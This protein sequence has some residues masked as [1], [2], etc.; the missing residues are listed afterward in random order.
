MKYILPFLFL[1]SSVNLFATLGDGDSAAD[2]T[3]TDIDG[4]VHNL[5]D[6]LDEGYSVIVDMSATWCGPCWSFHQ[7]GVLDDIWSDYGPSGEDMVITL[8]IEVDAATNQN[9]FF[10]SNGCNNST[11]GDWSSGVDFPLANPPSSEASDIA[12]DYSVTVLPTMYVISP[13]Q[14]V[15]AFT[16]SNTTYED[17]T[18]W[19]AYTF[20]LYNSTWEEGGTGC[21]DGFIDLH[22]FQGEGELEFEW[23]NGE[24]TEDL[25]GLPGGEYFVTITDDNLSGNGDF[26]VVIGPIEI[27][28]DED[29]E[30]MYID[31]YEIEEVF[32]FD[33]E[34]GYIEIFVEGGS[35]DFSYEWSNGGDESFIE[36]LGPGEYEVT[37]IDEDT[38]CELVDIFEVFGPEELEIDYDLTAAPCPQEFGLV[39]FYLEGATPPFTYIIEDED[40]DDDDI[41]LLP[42]YYEV[43]IIDNNDCE[44]YIEF[45]IE[46][47]DELVAIVSS[48]E[49]ELSCMN[50]SIS[51]YSDGSSEGNDIDYIW[52]DEEGLILSYAPS[53]EVTEAG[54]YILEVQREDSDCFET[55]MIEIF[56]D[57]QTPAITV[58]TANQIDCNSSTST[59]SAAGSSVGPQY[60]YNWTT[61]NGNI[62]GPTDS[63]VIVATMT[64]DYTLEIY[65]DENGCIS[66][67]TVTVTEVTLPIL[68]ISGSP[69]FCE[70]ESTDLCLS[71]LP[72][73]VAEWNL[74]G[75]N[76][77]YE[78]CINITEAQ[79]L[80]ATVTDT[81][82]GCSVSQSVTTVTMALPQVSL[83]GDLD[84]CPGS[85]TTIC[86]SNIVDMTYSW[87]ING[88]SLGSQSCIDLSMVADVTLSVTDQNTGCA[89]QETY[90]IIE[91][92]LPAISISKPE[93]LTCD[94]PEVMLD[95][96][97]DLPGYTVNWYDNNGINIANTE[98]VN[99]VNA[100]TYTAYVS[101]S[102]GCQTQSSVT[103][104][105]N[106][107]VPQFTIL[108]PAEL[109]C[110]NTEVTIDLMLNDPS[111]TVNW[112]NDSGDI[113]GNNEDLSVSD[114]GTYTAYI[115]S[116]NG[117]ETQSSVVVTANT[118]LPQFSITQPQE[119]N[120]NNA[121]VTIDLVLA[122]ATNSVSWT[123]ESG[124]I[125]SDTED[126]VVSQSGSYMATVLGNNGCTSSQIISVSADSS[127]LP[128]AAFEF[129]QNNLS[130][131]FTDQTLGN[132]YA[133]VWDFGDGN[134][135]IELDPNYLYSTAGYYLVCIETTN[136][137]GTSQTCQE[138]V[139]F[140]Q[141]E[142]SS[143]TT[144]VS[145]N[146]AADGQIMVG[147]I[148]GLG[149]YQ[150]NW[151]DNIGTDD[152]AQGLPAGTY[153]LIVQDEVGNEL[154]LSIDIIEPSAIALNPT[155]E[156]SPAGQDSG[157]I[158]LDIS[159]GTGMY[160]VLWEDGATATTRTDL[161]RGEYTVSV[162]DENLCSYSETFVIQGT[163]NSHE[164]D[165]LSSY[166]VSPN[167][168]T[169]ELYVTA[170][171]ESQLQ[172]QLSL[173]SITGERLL[174]TSDQLRTLD[175]KLDL[176]DIPNGIYLVE[177]RTKDKI[178]IK[179]V[180]ITK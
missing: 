98:D 7:D 57:T 27:E 63:L 114:S 165:G 15:K 69:E 40:Y 151:T 175:K 95:L 153:Q 103:V 90:T 92:A 24:T 137:C 60:E 56:S 136:D 14:Q 113:I 36:E 13:N 45:E 132:D 86:H 89:Q 53:L 71:L 78:N 4:Q 180:I 32:C 75:N 20:Q 122:D 102:D 176:T 31:D 6:Y 93:A 18:S 67:T 8:L 116:A 105:S 37:I 35:G 83:M 126:L 55:D 99:V 134:T 79:T 148:G 171:F 81:L 177:L 110:N 112:T 139:V 1:L 127:E 62:Q 94:R 163:S 154:L 39:E 133:V 3:V 23:S 125:L 173:I 152:T 101:N 10:G 58:S 160:T 131:S 33:S 120:C 26:E 64:G 87:S 107:D 47:E 162:T 44:A 29:G 147:V 156:N 157:S 161:A 172:V 12:G 167:P 179:K 166:V 11:F 106:T 46:S 82:T 146:G 104:T 124:V 16:G 9:C 149:E 141:M 117:C 38:D 2:F 164:I 168:A 22:P 51:L 21:G 150:Y 128:T 115:T 25:Y 109:T 5:Y 54:I 144:D 68:S 49:S 135:S 61:S 96:Q 85:M 129:T 52:S 50:T 178:S 73:Q 121:E 48:E 123:N 158:S 145:C 138:I 19:G 59:V 34:E 41:D 74:P 108:E 77:S 72:H 28:G 155:I 66:T 91:N 100:G 142:V 111:N 143:S 170:E 84:F 118:G 43:L 119:L 76:R 80:T 130:V 159:G 17:L 88:T 169:T 30:E 70:L 97:V 65:N 42:G 140:N 174:S